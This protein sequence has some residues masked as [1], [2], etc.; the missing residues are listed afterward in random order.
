MLTETFGF[1]PP[2][3]VL[4]PRER[5]AWQRR[6]WWLERRREVPCWLGSLL[7]HALVVI[8]LGS[9]TVPIT[10][11]NALGSL[12]L[13]ASYTGEARLGGS[14]SPVDLASDK[15]QLALVER[16]PEEI[17]NLTDDVENAPT[18]D[19]ADEADG[20]TAAVP[21]DEESQ[22]LAA[23]DR[24]SP[25]ALSD[26]EPPDAA[27][28]PPRETTS[29]AADAP[30]G[31]SEPPA[32]LG[33]EAVSPIEQSAALNAPPGQDTSGAD[34]SAAPVASQRKDTGVQD[35]VAAASVNTSRLAAKEQQPYVEVV[36]LF[37]EAD[38]GRL[39]RADADRA[40]HDFDRL[41][42]AAIPSLVY[43]LNKSAKI[44]ASCPVVV[45]T[46][47]LDM[48]LRKNSDPELL[49]Y[50]LDHLGDDV[51]DTAPHA[52]RLRALLEQWR[53][54]DASGSMEPDRAEATLKR[55]RSRTN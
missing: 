43:G 46:F 4:G 34:S 21:A 53:K 40:K 50:A 22:R 6:R 47:K 10:S 39:R 35:E 32:A 20:P 3:V 11:D 16:P 55:R 17:A 30:L 37:I 54:M 26:A 51:P 36:D 9:L 28:P 1:I 27:M 2:P 14:T 48:A 41:A 42:P 31:D 13:H 5:L 52:K 19:E 23:D 15:P 7:L 18:P 49:Q 33:L 8:V 38:L 25:T 12:Q 45:L 29:D 24:S 44:H